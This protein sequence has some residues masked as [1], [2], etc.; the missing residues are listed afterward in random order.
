DDGNNTPVGTALQLSRIGPTYISIPYN[1]AVEFNNNYT[2]A[3]WCNPF[4]AVNTTQYILSKAS[5]VEILYLPQVDQLRWFIGGV[6]SIIMTSSIILVNQR[7]FV[8]TVVDNSNKLCNIY[9]NNVLVSQESFSGIPVTNTNLI[10]LGN[11]SSTISTSTAFEGV[12]D[13]FNIWNVALNDSQIAD[14]WNNGNGR[15]NGDLT[16]LVAGYHFDE[17]AGTTVIDY[18][19]TGN[20]G[21]TNGR[22]VNGL[23][24]SVKSASVGVMCYLFDPE[25]E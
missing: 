22:Y 4:P 9:I 21:T 11:R 16:D 10:R 8:V 12:I 5:S 24:N 25:I 15:E 17:G 18:S 3:F 14:Q 19:P 6:A 13:E 2:I 1:P 7:N 23:I 20:N